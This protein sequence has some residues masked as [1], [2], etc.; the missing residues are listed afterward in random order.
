VLTV[1]PLVSAC[2]LALAES[3]LDRTI[4]LAP[5]RTVAFIAIPNPKAA[6]DDLQQCL[7]RMERAETA[8]LGRPID[9]LTARFGLS[10]SFDDKGPLLLAMLP[11]AAEGGPAI[12]LAFIPASDPPNFLAANLKPS[13]DDGADAYRTPE[14]MLLFGKPLANHAIVSTDATTVR[15][16]AP[17]DGFPA[18]FRGISSPRAIEIAARAD[19]VAWAG[20]AALADAMR[21]GAAMA[22]PGVEL[23]ERE[24]AMQER[25]RKMLEGLKSGLVAV[26]FDPLGVGIRA[27]AASTEG[28]ELASLLEGGGP[29]KATLDRMP[30]GPFYLAAAFDV[31]GIGGFSRIEELLAM[32]PEA[33]AFPIPAWLSGAARDVNSIQVAIYPSKLGIVAGGILNDAALFFRTEKAAAVKDALRQAVLATAGTVGGV[34][35]EPTWTEA[36]SL[37]GGTVADSFEVKETVLPPDQAG[38]A[39]AGDIAMQRIFTQALYGSR[40]F[41]GL[42]KE[43]SGGVVMTFSQRVDVFDRALAASGGGQTLGGDA[44]LASYSDWLLPA[45][46]AVGFVG[47]GQFGKL[48]KQLAGMVPG[49][50]D[51]SMLPEIPVSTEPV[52]FALSLDRGEFESAL[53]LPATALTLVYDQAVRGLSQAVP[54]AVGGEAA[55]P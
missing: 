24:R 25:T 27:W 14:G 29:G 12:P 22:P 28:S 16:Y 36:K 48:I 32:N 44:T 45:P 39:R 43:T 7:A 8:A 26:D 23:G 54:P 1:L 42:V 5:A 33:A 20:P 49:G 38:D 4:A 34:R 21:Q 2:C 6:S 41:N 9:Q 19:V 47:L 37:K 40:G 53:V 18:A 30:A 46:D 17:E 11:A 31:A 50:V 10:A 52:A 15:E 55:K 13:P 35:R 51:E 3:P